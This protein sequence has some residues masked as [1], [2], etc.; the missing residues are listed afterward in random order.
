MIMK[1]WRYITM[2]LKD[3]IKETL[4]QIAQGIVEADA[5]LAETGAAVNPRKLFSSIP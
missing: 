1:A 3:F 5:A 2:Y 4:V